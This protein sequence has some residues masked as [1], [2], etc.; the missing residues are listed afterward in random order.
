MLRFI[1]SYFKLLEIIINQN[2]NIMKKTILSITI[3]SFLIS[4]TQ[5]TK[6]STPLSPKEPGPVKL[7]ETNL[8]QP[9]YFEGD[10]TWTIEE[11]MKHYGVPGVSIAVI[12]DYKIDWIKSY[13]VMDKDTK[14]PVT[15]Q[16]LFQA[17]SISKPV[18]AYGALALVQQQKIDPDTDINTYLKSWKLPDNTF[19]ESKKVTLKHLVSHT[20]G[21]TV[22]GFLGYSPD[23][24]VPTLIQVLNGTP[25]AN[26]DAIVVDKMPGESF[27]YSGG[28]YTVMQQMMIDIED[29]PFPELMNNQVLKPLAMNNSTFNQPLLDEQL[30]AAATGYLPDGSMTKGKRH[31]YPEMAAAGLWT[32]AEDLAKFATNLQQTLKGTSEKVL[33]KA[34]TTQML[35]PYIEDFV[36]LGIFLNTYKDEI[37]FGHGGWDEG[38]SSELI[39]HKDKGYGVVVLTNSNHPKFISELIRSVALSYHWDSY[40]PS[41]KKMGLDS[42]KLAEVIGR[43]RINGNRVAQISKKDNR[44][45]KKLTGDASIELFRISD[46]TY[47]S[48]DREN[49]I[50][51]KVNPE[52][53]QMNLLLLD[54]NGEKIVGAFPKIGDEKKLPIELVEDGDFEAGLNA[55]STLLKNN[56]R[57]L[58][59]AENSLN[60]LAYELA[61][62]LNK[63]QMAHDV[64]KINT[65]LYPN[66]F[67]VYDSYGEVCMLME[68]FDLALENY[69]K[70]LEL[71]PENT[72]AIS[73]IKEIEQK[74]KEQV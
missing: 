4:C 8:I 27:R 46:S 23:L 20:G 72:N 39:A 61:F 6:E 17:G 7:V 26:S 19:T 53:N 41:Y 74:I 73:K 52:N 66:S 9:V 48:R 59:V 5:K 18:A 37:Y 29:K 50:Q 68:K 58:T 63:I 14:A 60:R 32:T 1:F 54:R 38:F 16:T 3:A 15:D 43:Y 67:N 57:D 13:G 31:T 71:N 55:Y 64:L 28:G 47:I 69:K 70:S 10:S 22:H 44:L 56:P 30:Q 62:N 33:S 12:K 49:P 65:I 45:Y 35:T 34:M 24:T 36:G 25:P 51:F 40:V 2:Q 42:T 21:L 11:R